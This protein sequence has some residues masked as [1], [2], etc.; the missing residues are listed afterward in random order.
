MQKVTCEDK[1]A[2]ICQ[3]QHINVL[4]HLFS[5][6]EMLFLSLLHRFS[7]PIFAQDLTTA[8]KIT[9]HGPFCLYHQQEFDKSVRSMI[10]VASKIYKSHDIFPYFFPSLRLHSSECALFQGIVFLL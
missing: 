7:V 9:I 6:P 5:V 2:E 10:Q 8:S 1:P 4:Q 3:A